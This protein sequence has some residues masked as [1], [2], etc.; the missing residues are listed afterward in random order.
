MRDTSIRSPSLYGIFGCS[1]APFCRVFE[2]SVTD[3]YAHRGGRQVGA[4]SK[5]G[6]HRHHSVT[7][8]NLLK[9]LFRGKDGSP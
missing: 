2:E 6:P 8:A 9:S 5:I 3:L 7:L 1:L 4:G